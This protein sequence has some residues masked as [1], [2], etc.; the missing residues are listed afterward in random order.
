M[1]P[2]ELSG[3]KRTFG[4]NQLSEHLGS[5]VC[6]HTVLTALTGEFYENTQTLTLTTQRSLSNNSSNPSI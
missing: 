5:C 1:A 4:F 3:L 2:L 6:N